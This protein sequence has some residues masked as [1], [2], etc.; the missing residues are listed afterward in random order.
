MSSW[1]ACWPLV[2]ICSSRQDVKPPL[3]RGLLAVPPGQT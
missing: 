3:T 1:M 2:T